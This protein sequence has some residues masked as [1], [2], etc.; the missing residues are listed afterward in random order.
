[1]IVDQVEYSTQS[2]ICETAAGIPFGVAV[3][4][5]G[6]ADTGCVLG[7]GTAL[8]FIGLA[9]RDVTLVPSPVDPQQVALNTVDKYGLY[10][11]VAVM[12]RGH[13]WVQAGSDV[14]AGTAVY[15]DTV[16]GALTNASTGMSALGSIVFGSNPAAGNT[17]TLNG[18]VITFEASGAT[19]SQVNIGPTLGNTL[20]N[21]AAF[22][23]TNA[24][25][26]AQVAKFNA[27]AL[28]ASPGGAGQGSGA[29][30]LALAVIVPGVG[31]ATPG[32][33]ATGNAIVYSTNV[34]G[35]TAAGTNMVGG[36]ANTLV[37]PIPGARWISSA[38]A[39][40]LAQVS[41]ASQF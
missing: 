28:P 19:G 34:P 25:A 20:V 30:T 7:A 32:A 5:G 12:T 4:L 38:S 40:Q 1:M 6:G 36:S 31:N 26:D 14:A 9:Q 10:T 8:T 24:L 16:T 33:T 29:N 3:S 35:A 39:G 21:M 37:G 17:V 41:L 22:I 23:N 2:F 13:M 11:Q 15:A 18:T 27:V